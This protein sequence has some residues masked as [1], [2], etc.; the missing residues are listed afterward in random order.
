MTPFILNSHARANQV[1]GA[2][3]T[4]VVTDKKGQVAGYYCLASGVHALAQ[5]P[6]SVRRNMADPVP[7]AIPGRLAVDRN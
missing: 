3:R 6:G 1:S 7:M 4:Y 2:L 5:A